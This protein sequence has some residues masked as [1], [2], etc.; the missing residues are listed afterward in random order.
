MRCAEARGV[1]ARAS[2]WLRPGCLAVCVC[3]FFAFFAC[4]TFRVCVHVRWRVR[5]DRADMITDRAAADEAGL[6]RAQSVSP[7]ATQVTA[8]GAGGGSRR[9]CPACSAPFLGSGFDFAPLVWGQKRVAR[10]E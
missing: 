3:R 8:H 9:A 4:A 1:A 10:V 2:A 6:V 7:C 5:Y